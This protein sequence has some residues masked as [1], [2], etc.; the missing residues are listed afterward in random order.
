ML[1]AQLSEFHRVLRLA[2]SLDDM[3]AKH[4]AQ[5]VLSVK[6]VARELTRL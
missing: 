1:Q 2:T 6:V 5:F 3:I 4:D